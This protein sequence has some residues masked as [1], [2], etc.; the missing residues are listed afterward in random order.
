MSAWFFLFSSVAAVPAILVTI[1]ASLLFQYGVPNSGIPMTRGVFECDL[2]RPDLLRTDHQRWDEATVTMG[3]DLSAFLR[4]QSIDGPG[5][6]DFFARQVYYRSL[7]EGALFAVNSRGG[8]R[9]LAM[10]NPYEMDIARLV[11]PQAIA[12]LSERS[13]VIV[14]GDRI[15]VFT[16]LP[17][18]DQIYLYAARVTDPKEMTTQTARA[19]AALAN[20]RQLLVR[21]RALQLQFNTAL[22]IVSLLIV[23]VAV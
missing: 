21:A 10:V 22:L 2:A 9:S 14:T 1:L 18:S 15:Q 23:G 20:Y 11:T 16:R 17:G 3:D 12:R 5:F 19:E 8:L 7:S 4:E 6:A 13:V